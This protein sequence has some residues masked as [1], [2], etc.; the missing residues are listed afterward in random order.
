MLEQVETI[1]DDMRAMMKKLKKASYKTNMEIFTERHGHYF[2]EM[3]EI[4]AAAEDKLKRA[5]EISGCFCNAVQK[6]YEVKG[7][8][9]S[10]VQTDLNFFM[11]YYVFPSIL[12]TESAEA[13]LLADTLCEQWGSRFKDSKIGYTDYDTLYQSFKE[14]IFGLF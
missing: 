8:I 9:K 13:K 1:F 10:T 6:H 11:I 2:Q 3:A 4:M 7:K 5:R 14:K 12:Q